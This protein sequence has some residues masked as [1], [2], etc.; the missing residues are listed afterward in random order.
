MFEYVHDAFGKFAVEERGREYRALGKGLN[1]GAPLTGSEWPE[2]DGGDLVDDGCFEAAG[3]NADVVDEACPDVRHGL[4]KHFRKR[5]DE[6]DEAFRPLF[7]SPGLQELH[8]VYIFRE[9]AA[10]VL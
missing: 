7:C 4:W 6:L 8:F 2:R 3:G 10:F 9:F 5:R 1:D